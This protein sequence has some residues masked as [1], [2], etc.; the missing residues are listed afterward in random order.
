MTLVLTILVVWLAVAIVVLP[1]FIEVVKR[2]K[3]GVR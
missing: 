3:R 1:L 2:A